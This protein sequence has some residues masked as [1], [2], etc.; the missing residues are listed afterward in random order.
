MQPYNKK[1][2]N[3][4][5][6]LMPIS[7]VIAFATLYC[8]FYVLSKINGSS[9]KEL[10]Q[11]E[12]LWPLVVFL[13]GFLFGI[14]V[15]LIFINCLAFITP[16]LRR[17]FQAEVS[18]TGRHSFSKAMSGLFKAAAILGVITIIGT[19]IFLHQLKN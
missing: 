18:E 12:T 15:G 9:I 16:P 6:A 2:R 13:P 7:W 11:T 17:I 14:V 3:T 10:I 19:L 1:G 4:R 8:L 5:L